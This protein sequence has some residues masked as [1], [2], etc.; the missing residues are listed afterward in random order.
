[1]TAPIA[2]DAR[3]ALYR[4][5]AD[6]GAIGDGRTVAL[7]SRTG[8][9]DWWCPARFDAPSVFASLLDHG[10]GG[11]FRVSSTR[12]ATSE[13]RYIPDTN[14]LETTHATP[15]GR[16]RVVDLA[17]SEDLTGVDNS[18]IV[19]RIEGLEGAVEMEV[20]FAPRFQYGRTQPRFVD[21]PHGVLLARG[22]G[23][24]VILTGLPLTTRRPGERSAR[25]VVRAGERIDLVLR[26]RPLDLPVPFAHALARAPEALERETVETDR[27]WAARTRYD[28]D[29]APMLRRSALALR[30]L[31]HRRSGAIV[32]AATTSLPE[33]VGGVRNWDY[34]FA[35][36]RDGAIAAKALHDVGHAEEADAFRGWLAATLPRD[37]AD[38]RIMYTLRGSSDLDEKELPHLDGW[39]S[40]KPVRIGNGAAGQRQ[41]DVYGELV[42]FLAT[43]S[44]GPLRDA[45]WRLVASVAAFVARTWR[46]PDSGIWEMRCEPRHFTLSKAMAWAALDRAAKAAAARGEATLAL[47][48][49]REAA[50]VREQVL[51][52]GYDATL[53]AFSQAYG[54]PLLDASNLLLPIIGIVDANDPRM[55]ATVERTLDTLVSDGLVYRYLDA[56]DGLPG[57]EATF[58][59]CTFWLIEV[60][61]KQG[62]VR[63][64]RA[65]YDRLVARATPLGLFAEEMAPFTGEHLGNFPQGF[66]HAGHIQ[67]ALALRKAERG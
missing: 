57:G 66:P 29:D 46:E 5:L 48:W 13:M 7:V 1:M 26:H 64:A 43:T 28:G 24:I 50:D 19:R 34:R 23:E 63:D 22:A 49:S 59:Y 9:I 47:E 61:A 2:V 58:T 36:V 35:W 15:S 67:A 53:G 65:L 60:L 30:L 37:A 51:S 8:S 41:L 42:E 17:P 55:V 40:S 32:A 20:A 11:S 16:V 45:D 33:E 6:Y 12:E 52:Q 27:A 56:G 31:Q 54:F 10:Q 62:R 14:V 18:V 4:P 44:V 21:A 25:V 38:M 39:R 3:A